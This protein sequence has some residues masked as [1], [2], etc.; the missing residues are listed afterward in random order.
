MS[1]ISSARSVSRE[2]SVENAVSQIKEALDGIDCLVLV[3]TADAE[4]SGVV[5]DGD[6]VYREVLPLGEGVHIVLTLDLPT[7]MTAG[8]HE[9]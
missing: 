9:L 4:V 7:K 2:R 3:G 6:E 5:D 8:I 1:N